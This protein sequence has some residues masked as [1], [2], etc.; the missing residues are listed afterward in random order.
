MLCV[1][2]G[3]GLLAWKRREKKRDWKGR[4]EEEKRKRKE[5]GKSKK[6]KKK[7]K[8]TKKKKKGK[9]RKE[10]KKKKRKKKEKECTPLVHHQDRPHK[11]PIPL[12]DVGGRLILLNYNI[13]RLLG[14]VL[15]VMI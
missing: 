1:L 13:F 8:R 6:K 10:R 9:K 14:G 5:E 11:D 4:G 3:C 15:F 12:E 7:R 2:C